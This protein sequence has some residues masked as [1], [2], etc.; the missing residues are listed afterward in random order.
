[1][2]KVGKIFL[3]VLIF[4]LLTVPVRAAEEDPVQPLYNNISSIVVGL[5]IDEDTGIAH[6]T[7]SVDAYYDVPVEVLVQLQVYQNGQWKTLMS[8]SNAGIGAILTGGYY[9]VESGYTYRTKVTGSIC[10]DLGIPIESE[11]GTK[12]VYY[13]AS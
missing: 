13:P 6:C 10:N 9:G 4:A 2:K 5:N 12:V 1:M 11:V 8:W 7:G 3:F